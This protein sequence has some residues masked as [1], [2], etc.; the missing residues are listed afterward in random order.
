[1]KQQFLLL[2][3]GILSCIVVFLVLS[4]NI[5]SASIPTFDPNYD[6]SWI[7]RIFALSR[8]QKD[9]SLVNEYKSL[10]S[11]AI[12]IWQKPNGFPQGLHHYSK[13]SLRKI[14]KDPNN[15]RILED[16]HEFLYFLND[17]SVCIPYLMDYIQNYEFFGLFEQ[18]ISE[19]VKHHWM[20]LFVME[21][22]ARDK[23]SHSLESFSDPSGT[24]NTFSSSPSSLP[25]EMEPMDD[26]LTEG[27]SLLQ[28]LEQTSNV[29]DFIDD[30]LLFESSND[31]LNE[32]LELIGDEIIKEKES[33]ELKNPMTSNSG[34][35]LKDLSQEKEE[36]SLL[37]ELMEEMI[38]ESQLMQPQASSST[39]LETNELSMNPN[40]PLNDKIVSSEKSD[41]LIHLLTENNHPS[42]EK[43]ELSNNNHPTI[44]TTESD[45]P[46]K[47]N[48]LKETL[49]PI[50]NKNP[51]TSNESNKLDLYQSENNHPTHIL[52]STTINPSNELKDILKSIH[53]NDS[54]DSIE[55]NKT[56]STES[57]NESNK[58]QS[59]DSIES[60][61]IQSND[62][63]ESKKIQS[64]ESSEQNQMNLTDD[65]GSLKHTNL[66]QENLQ[67][68]SSEDPSTQLQ[69]MTKVSE[70]INTSDQ[71]HSSYL[72]NSTNNDFSNLNDTVLSTLESLNPSLKSEEN[73]TMNT[74]LKLQ[75]LDVNLTNDQVHVSQQPS[76]QTNHNIS[77]AIDY[78]IKRS[79]LYRIFYNLHERI[80]MN[81]N[82]TLSQLESTEHWLIPSL[83]KLKQLSMELDESLNI[84]KTYTDSIHNTLS[85]MSTMITTSIPS[86]VLIGRGYQLPAQ[87]CNDIQPLRNFNF[88][89]TTVWIEPSKNR[90]PNKSFRVYCVS[91]HEF[92]RNNDGKRSPS[93][94]NGSE[95]PR[96]WMLV[97]KKSYSYSFFSNDN[98]NSTACLPFS[99]S[100]NRNALAVFG[101]K[102]ET[103]LAFLSLS[104][105][106]QVFVNSTMTARVVFTNEQFKN[107]LSDVTTSIG[108][109]REFMRAIAEK[110]P[111]LSEALIYL[112]I[113]KK[114]EN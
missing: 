33:D 3:F 20:H 63:I 34:L 92:T 21:N 70:K 39:E 60:N 6:L 16:I 74:P 85:A 87:T 23:A 77:N 1:M 101:P 46:L 26:L 2:L 27:E 32:E 41:S 22:S 55:S 48:N 47:L 106:D 62:S 78:V 9:I 30:T 44:T 105:F 102:A 72:N 61:K 43:N 71:K 52:P 91:D 69:D 25:L 50:E 103:P 75:E 57:S 68:N 111:P 28:E 98:N 90:D 56:K 110:I 67:V 4:P 7:K 84:T 97:A 73:N 35:E 94:S 42:T 13:S 54:N 81:Y 95:K 11:H 36:N 17:Q 114:K 113:E 45:E 10:M 88:S 76:L 58:I 82:K 15:R 100:L 64:T 65:N 8:S 49:N 53:S 51:T 14:F 19:W 31:D 66:S 99:C 24:S 104:E 79:K 96:M 38:E 108:T 18:C 37:N 59:N 29:D 86:N 83:T 93:S 40:E 89:L 112:N 107:I 12:Q 109:P 5:E 80:M